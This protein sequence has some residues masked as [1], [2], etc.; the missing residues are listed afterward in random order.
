MIKNK[1]EKVLFKDIV[2]LCTF[3]NVKRALLRLYP[4]QKNVIHGYEYVFKTLKYMRHRNNKEGLVIDIRRVGR[5]KNAY[6]AIS[7]VCTEKGIQQ[8]YALEYTPWSKWLGYEV[9]KKVLKKMPKEEIAAH[10]L[11]EMTF[12]GFT[13]NRI[14]KKL[15]A[16]RKRVKDIKEG[17]VKTIPHEDRVYRDRI[18]PRF[19]FIFLARVYRQ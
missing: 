3:K 6:F 10:C 16:L 17:K 2:K 8:P 13:Q 7:G 11:W 1:T 19:P 18:H 15:Y 12:M 9:D 14:R 5:G 4:D